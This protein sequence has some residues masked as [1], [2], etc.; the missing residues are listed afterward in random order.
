MSDFT[1]HTTYQIISIS[2]S[3]DYFSTIESAISSNP[4]FRII[5][6]I[7]TNAEFV[8]Q[9]FE[10]SNINYDA[11]VVKTYD[12]FI[13]NNSNERISSP[14]PEYKRIFDINSK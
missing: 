7:S 9:T 12:E 2:D 10:E 5:G 13:K 4:D 11:N 8:S 3:T 14:I 6:R 1:S